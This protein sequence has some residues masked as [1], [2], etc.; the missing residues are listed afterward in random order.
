MKILIATVA[1][2]VL[3]LASTDG[4]ARGGHGGGGGGRGGGGGGR[5]FGG[6]AGFGRG[7]GGFNRGFAG[8]GFGRGFGRGYGF[9][10]PGYGYY[11]DCAWGPY[12]NPY[13][14]Y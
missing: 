11:G 9:G 7:F 3:G 13:C 12:Y 6:P 5:G 10:Y 1:I 14:Y 4:F 8:R 2:V